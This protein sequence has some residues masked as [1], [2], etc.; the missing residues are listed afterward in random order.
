MRTFN[1]LVALRL[2]L[3]L[4][5]DSPYAFRFLPS[6]GPAEFLCGS[7]ARRVPLNVSGNGGTGYAVAP[8]AR[9][10]DDFLCYDCA[11]ERTRAEMVETGRANLYLVRRQVNT[12]TRTGFYIVYEVVDWPGKLR[13]T[14]TDYRRSPGGGGFGA[15]RTDAWF[16]GPDGFIWHAV[17]RGDMGLARCKRTKARPV[18][19]AV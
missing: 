2:A 1:T 14:C 10:E 12:A 19:T 6:F 5:A 4:P 18:V 11:A 16:V 7:C 9:G 17:N 15:Q 8:N 3:E 13:F